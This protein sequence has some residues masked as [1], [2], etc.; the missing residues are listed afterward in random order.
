[1]RHCPGDGGG[2]IEIE[3]EGERE[4]EGG[5]G[6]G[7]QKVILPR[8]IIKEDFFLKEGYVFLEQRV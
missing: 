5:V 2:D 3:G 1:M 8:I 6:N 7:K 4:R